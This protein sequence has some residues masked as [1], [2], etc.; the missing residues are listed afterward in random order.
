MSGQKHDDDK[1]PEEGFDFFSDKWGKAE[2]DDSG[3][4]G[5]TREEAIRRRR[6]RNLAIAGVLAAWVI[7]IFVVTVVKLGPEVL[8]RPL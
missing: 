7:L 8:N 5:L 6:G 4:P 3:T 1:P 2:L